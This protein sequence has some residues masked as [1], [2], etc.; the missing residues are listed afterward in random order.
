MIQSEGFGRRCSPIKVEVRLSNLHHTLV[1]LLAKVANTA[2]HGAKSL[3]PDVK[4][5]FDSFTSL[6]TPFSGEKLCD[7]I[8]FRQKTFCS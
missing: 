2:V 8:R 7:S 6:N 4:Q 1:A 3:S 5:Y